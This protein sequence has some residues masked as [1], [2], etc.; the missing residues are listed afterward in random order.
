[1]QAIDW[2]QTKPG[3]DVRGWSEMVGE[4]ARCL[5]MQA[6]VHHVG[7]LVGDPLWHVQPMEQTS[8]WKFLLSEHFQFYSTHVDRRST[9]TLL[10]LTSELRIVA[11]IVSSVSD[12][13][14]V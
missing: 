2:C 4:V 14:H 11:T 6:A 5:T 3:S 13:L 1:M 7:Q 9:T 12:F 8:R 10:Q